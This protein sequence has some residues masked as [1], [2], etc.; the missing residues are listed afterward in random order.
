MSNFILN[1]DVNYQKIVGD[2]SS[3]IATSD[4]SA[5]YTVTHNLGYIPSARAWYQPI[6]DRWYVLTNNQLSN[7]FSD[8]LNSAG[9]LELTTT[10]ATINLTNYSGGA[11]SVPVKLRL[12][13]DE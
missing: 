6:A 9:Y 1:T 8:F 5:T 11:I 10:T 2:Y 12:Y 3:T 4:A 13:L 7:G